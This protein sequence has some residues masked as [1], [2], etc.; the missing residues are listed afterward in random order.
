M[1]M[2]P[3]CTVVHMQATYPMMAN[4][5]LVQGCRLRGNVL[6]VP[7]NHFLTQQGKRLNQWEERRQPSGQQR[8][9]MKKSA[10]K[11]AS[12]VGEKVTEE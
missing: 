4:G 11:G 2:Q 9:R 7:R 6:P 3:S 1:M 10:L 5:A 8:E 12:F